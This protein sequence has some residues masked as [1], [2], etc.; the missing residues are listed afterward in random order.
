MTQKNKRIVHL[1][2]NFIQI[3]KNIYI[4]KKSLNMYFL[5]QYNLLK[6][7]LNYLM[8]KGANEI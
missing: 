1:V 3:R 7:L 6:T 2:G 5:R 8:Q 4:F